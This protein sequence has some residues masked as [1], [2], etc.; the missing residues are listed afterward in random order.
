MDEPAGDQKMSDTVVEADVIIIGSGVAGAMAAYTLANKGVKVAI[1]EAGP[2]IDRAAI[3]KKFTQSHKFDFSSGYPNEDWAPR[4]DWDPAEKP[5]FD[6][7]G[8]A[9]ANVE[10]LRNVGGTTWHWS[11][12]AIRLHPEDMK[13]K[14]TYGVGIDWHFDYAELEP[15]YSEAEKEMGVSGD[16][17]DPHPPRSKPFPLPPIPRSYSDKIIAPKLEKMGIKFSTPPAARNS[18]AYDGRSQC[19]GFGTC[20]PICPSGAQYA[21]VVHVNKSEKLGVRVLENTRVD[22]IITDASGKISEVHAKRPDGTDVTARGR[23]FLLAANGIESPRLLLMSA[24]E[25][26]SKGLANSSGRVGRYFFEHPGLVCRMVMPAPV[27]PRGPEATMSSDNFR[28]GDFRRTRA[29]FTFSIHN[30]A[31]HFEATSDLLEKGAEPP[32]LDSAI[33]DRVV[34]MIDM[35]SHMEQLPSEKNGITLDWTRRDRAGQP[36]MKHYYSFSDYENAGFEAAKETFRHITKALDAELLS[37]QGPVTEHHPLGMAMMG[38]DK[39]TSVVDP[40]CRSHDHPNLFIVGTA[41]FPSCGMSRPTLTIAA[42]AIRTA[43]EI[44][45]QLKKKR[46]NRISTD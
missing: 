41:V 5:Y 15:Y 12:F 32:S 2:R 35:S 13:I 37:I 10:Y 19:M 30:F 29:G 33:R 24:N 31:H 21:A 3:V 43:E 17:K 34:R 42:L 36:V 40:H 4:P 23:I 26:Y 18:R 6:H 46:I 44:A 1:L 11:G 45:R 22:R 14:S 25:T 8:P 7:I 20:S 27:Y 39:K 38:K 9:Q 28:N 16:D